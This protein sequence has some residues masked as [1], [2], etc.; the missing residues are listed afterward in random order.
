MP[1]CAALT[2][3][4]IVP[5]R[6]AD[7]PERLHAYIESRRHEPFAW[8]RNDCAMFA[9][10]AVC[11][12]TGARLGSLLPA[13]WGSKGDAAHL[14]ADLGGIEAGAVRMLGEPLRGLPA[15]FA[16]RGS[17]V[18]VPIQQRLTLG[19]MMGRD[20]WCAPGEA[21]LVFRP[22]AEVRIAWVI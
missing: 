11:A 5:P 8:G 6:L 4:P 15:R 16:P 18:L 17:V 14:L 2:L 10:G 21:G 9:A 1:S 3:P 7:W 13:V 19:L 20:V 12:M 22:A